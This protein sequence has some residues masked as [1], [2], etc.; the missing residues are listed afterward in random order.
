MKLRI[1]G[2]SIRM[3]LTQPEMEQLGEIG[4]VEEN[5]NFGTTGFQKLNYAIVVADIEELSIVYDLNGIEVQVPNEQANKWINTTLV[6]L[7]NFIPIGNNKKLRILVE[8]DF[9]CLQP[10]PHEDETNHFP[11]P[12]EHQLKC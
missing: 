10:R 1:K 12:Q 7:E 11:N 4:R 8:K 9:K 3:R 6:G 2:N 5:V